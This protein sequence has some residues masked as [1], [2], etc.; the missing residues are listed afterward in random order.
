MSPGSAWI[1]LR[2]S[3]FVLATLSGFL[4][5]A[6]NRSQWM[7]LVAIGI[8]VYAVI[9]TIILNAARGGPMDVVLALTDIALCGGI[10]VLTRDPRGVA[11]LCTYAFVALAA[12][13]RPPTIGMTGAFLAGL[14]YLGVI[15]MT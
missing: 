6:A 11:V 12:L 9:S 3:L 14:S 10:A 7:L 2:I 13:G 4:V 1:M 8:A 5:D 15:V